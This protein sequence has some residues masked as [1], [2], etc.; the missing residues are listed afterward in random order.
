VTGIALSAT[1]AVAAALTAVAPA[2]PR[3]ALIASP[4]RVV[5]DGS[6]KALVHVATPHGVELVDVALAPYALDP[7]GR[8]RLGGAV[9]PPRWVSARPLHLRVGPKGAVVTLATAPPRGAAPGDRAFAL[10][11]TTRGARGTGV[12][13]RLRIG[14]LVI[15]HVPGRAVRRLV[16][17]PLRVRRSRR[18]RIL[19]LTIR[20]SGNVVERLA[21]GRLVLALYR[22]GRIVARLRPPARELLPRSR[23]IVTSALRLPLRGP[24]NVRVTLGAFVHSYA[25]QL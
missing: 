8:P 11:L 7:G 6:T 23:A 13:V 2:P 25:L 18:V 12:G 1:A 20:N 21:P 15:A 3:P 17:G 14:V 9:H 5:L 10:V 4:G 19:E 16:I 22:R 24:A